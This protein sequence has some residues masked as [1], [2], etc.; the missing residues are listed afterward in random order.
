MGIY[1][2]DITWNMKK[3]VY[4]KIIAALLINLKNKA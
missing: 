4:Q 1:P 3:I 2:E